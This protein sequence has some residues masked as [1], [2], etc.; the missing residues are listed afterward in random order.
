LF[1]QKKSEVRKPHTPKP[2]YPAKFREQM[3]ERVKRYFKDP[4]VA[5]ADS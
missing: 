1:L 4:K 5:Y 2:P 3:T